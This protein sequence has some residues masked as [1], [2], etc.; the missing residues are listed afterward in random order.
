MVREPSKRR[1]LLR[2]CELHVKKE[3]TKARQGQA[4]QQLEVWE[5]CWWLL[6]WAERCFLGRA[7]VGGSCCSAIFPHDLLLPLPVRY[8]Q[9]PESD[10]L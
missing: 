8:A 6:M 5:G 4:R 2:F 1:H 7:V 9:L 10:K 3:R